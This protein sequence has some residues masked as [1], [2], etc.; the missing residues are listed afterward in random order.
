MAN[1]A[2]KIQKI[3]GNTLGATP[4]G[5]SVFGSFAA[6][7][8]SYSTDPDAIQGSPQFDGGWTN[9]IIGTNS[10]A[11]EDMNSIFYVISYQ[12]AYLLQKGLP[13]WGSTTEYF[14]GDL[15]KDSSGNIYKSI[16][17]NNTNNLLTDSAWWSLVSASYV[18]IT[19]AISGNKT[20]GSSDNGKAF[21]CD[22]SSSGIIFTL[23]SAATAGNGFRFKVID[24]VGNFSS[25]TYPVYLDPNGSDKIQNLNANYNLNSDFGSWQVVCDGTQWYLE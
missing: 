12:L 5:L 1:L 2:R 23:P 10:P 6:G 25:T 21:V 20:I 11:L 4:N 17:D 16:Q 18:A 14:I 8:P 19:E 15:A 9:S 13:E 24:K 22:N 3:F 7:A